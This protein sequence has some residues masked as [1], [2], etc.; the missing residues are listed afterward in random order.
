MGFH[1]NGHK[2]EGPAKNVRDDLEIAHGAAWMVGNA[3]ALK[4]LASVV[5]P[6][7]SVHERLS[8]MLLHAG[9][10][11]KVKAIREARAAL[12]GGAS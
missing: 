10:S 12:E 9:R 6:W 2:A 11:G 4:A 3:D 7:Q 5:T 8:W 1:D